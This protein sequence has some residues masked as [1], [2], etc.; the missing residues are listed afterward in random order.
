MEELDGEAGPLG[1]GATGAKGR[2]FE[3]FVAIGD[4]QTEGV[5]DLPNADGTDRG[6]ADRFASTLARANPG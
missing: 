5:G 6:W 4:S 3:R 1:E 2:R